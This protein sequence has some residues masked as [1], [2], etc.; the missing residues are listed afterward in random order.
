MLFFLPIHSISREII[1][2]KDQV[3]ALIFSFL[4]KMHRNLRCVN[5]MDFAEMHIWQGF[6]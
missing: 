3:K 4:P 6:H 1:W 2:P 5:A